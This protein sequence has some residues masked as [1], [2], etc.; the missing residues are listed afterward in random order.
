M[1]AFLSFSDILEVG[2]PQIA[3]M[4]RIGNTYASAQE[5]GAIEA[6]ARQ[7]RRVEGVVVQTYAAAAAVARKA[8]ELQE[9]ADVWEKMSWF[10]QAAL[11]ALAALKRKYPSCGTTELYDLALDYKLA[12][13]KR[14]KGAL[15][16]MAC[17]KMDF[18]KGLLP[19]PS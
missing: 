14:C 11:Q 12:A 16:E 1:Q 15:E 7:V 17:L 19:E 13:D 4:E 3:E 8:D 2:R 9:V 6:F 10:C 5:P 18:P